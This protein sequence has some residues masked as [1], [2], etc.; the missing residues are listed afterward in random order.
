MG[1]YLLPEVGYLEVQQTNE[2]RFEDPPLPNH[3]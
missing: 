1:P 2:R 3:R